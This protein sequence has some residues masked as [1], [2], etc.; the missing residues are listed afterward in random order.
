MSAPK[1]G[2]SPVERCPDCGWWYAVPAAGNHTLEQCLA[3]QAAQPLP[4]REPAS[5]KLPN[6]GV[7]F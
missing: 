3:N 5:R 1:K 6:V 4:T 2:L 7:K